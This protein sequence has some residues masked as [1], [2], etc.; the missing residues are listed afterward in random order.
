[1]QFRVES[2]WT[3]I[4]GAPVRLIQ[5]YK[6]SFRY[7]K[8]D[9]ATTY[10]PRFASGRWDGFKSLFDPHYLRFPT[11]LLSAALT[12]AKREGHTPEI[13]M[14]LPELPERIDRRVDLPELRDYQIQAV[15]Q[16]LKFKRG[17]IRIPT[18]GGKT[19][20]AISLI[21]T[22]GVRRS[23]FLVPNRTIL[24]QT[25]RRFKKALPGTTIL[26]WGDGSQDVTAEHVDDYV[27]V[28][29]T[30]SAWKRTHYP[31]ITDAQM[32][33]VDESHHVAAETFH[34]VTRTCRN[35]RYLIGLSATPYR[36][37]GADMELTGWIGPPIFSIGY[38]ELI[39]GGYLVPPRFVKVRSLEEAF[40]VTSGLK[41]LMFSEKIKELQD[42]GPTLEK[43]NTVILTG[44]DKSSTIQG[45]LRRIEH[46]DITHIAA[47]PIFDEGLDMPALDAIVFLACGR[48]RVRAMQRIG[49]GMRPYPGKKEV[50]VVDM[51]DKNY[52]SRYQA[53]MLEPA[54]ASRLGK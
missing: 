47:T 25:V 43:Y 21:A 27:L 54:F 4:I 36:D 23:L 37:D 45:C 53:Y 18:G 26:K 48:G 32:V 39:S 11:G 35:A 42:Y 49:R 40:E 41:T 50:L 52:R 17:V 33:I 7:F 24:N 38:E 8:K 12:I 31:Q 46:G 30:Q 44:K 29:T 10:N 3:T 22:S 15:E 16:A 13:D 9:E 5:V 34:T 19:E 14:R 1:M 28:S 20:A 2:E 6:D 51:L